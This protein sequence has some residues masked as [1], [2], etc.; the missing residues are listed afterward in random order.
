MKH[1]TCP[2]IPI[3]SIGSFV[4]HLRLSKPW[5]RSMVRGKD[6]LLGLLAPQFR[7][8][9]WIGRSWNYS[10]STKTKQKNYNRK[11]LHNP[12]RPAVLI[13]LLAHCKDIH[14]HCWL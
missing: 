10:Y 7:E 11:A 12:Q 5:S 9:G 4:G 6:S 8:T 2:T 14:I 13:L 3:A 1:C